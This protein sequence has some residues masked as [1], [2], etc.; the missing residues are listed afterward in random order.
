MEKVIM[1]K[2]TILRVYEIP[3]IE[4]CA[5]EPYKFLAVSIIFSGGAG[6]GNDGGGGGWAGDGDNGGEVTGA[7]LLDISFDDPWDGLKEG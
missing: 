4:V 3:Q 6:N 1:Q 5:A 7:K 2:T